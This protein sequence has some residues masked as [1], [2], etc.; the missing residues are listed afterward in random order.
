MNN[1]FNKRALVALLILTTL[2]TVWVFLAYLKLS[3]VE[4]STP[5]VQDSQV[6]R[7]SIVDS[8][9]TPL[10]VQVNLYNIGITS[11]SLKKEEDFA[12]DIAP[13]LNMTKDD[14]LNLITQNHD[15]RFYYIKKKVPEADYSK[16]KALTDKKHYNFV[17]FDKIP[18]RYY[19]EN[20][21]ASNL[22]GFMGDDGVGLSGIE[23]SMQGY[24]SPTE[25]TDTHFQSFDND[26]RPRGKSIPDQYK[27]VYLTIDAGLQ[28]KLELLSRNTM[29]ETQCESMMLLAADAK[30]GEILTYISMP[31][32][33]LN[34]YTKASPKETVDR[35]AVVMFEP[36]SVFKI[37]TV[38][39][40]KDSGL[41][42]EDESFLCDGVYTKRTN[43]GETIRIKCL[44]HHGWVTA[45]DA[46]RYS[47]NDALAQ[48]ADRMSDDYFI[49]RIRDMG[50][51]KKTFIEL[52]SETAGLVKDSQST[53]W[54]ARSK[55]TISIGQE[56]SV[57][58]IQM[59][60]AASAI[61]NGGIPLKLTVIKK[62]TQKDGT[63]VY[64]HTPLPDERVLSEATARYILSCMQTTAETGTGSRARLHGVTIGVKTGTAQM[65]SPTGGYS[66]TDFLSNCMAI[67]PVEDPKIILYIVVVKAK[68][69]TYAGR[70]VAPVIAKAA[71]EIIDYLGLA[72]GDAQSFSH[73]GKVNIAP[74][75]IEK[76][77]TGSLL[78]NFLGMTLGDLRQFMA[79]NNIK[80]TDPIRFVINGSGWVREQN[81]PAGSPITADMTIELNLSMDQDPIREE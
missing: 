51:G 45:R 10:A 70:I 56:I 64:E 12:T 53:T 39:V 18:G 37:F 40:A 69:E 48:I 57:S 65:A 68:G 59:V 1:F 17:V 66:D 71:D 14:L 81:P 24:L 15:T 67:F 30:T 31:E 80:S 2:W 29:D 35:P 49:M 26:G 47:C 74:K 76:L 11:N 41:I 55:A 22:I 23:Y 63:L 36:G 20:T 61:A 21:L 28:Y 46:L 78:P 43:R 8:K 13:L 62:I 72:R 60:H 27:N 33:N 42:T 50:F 44:E 73:T 7:G 19:P 54:S 32:A 79:E 77:T 75:E 52:P 58:A 16:I 38:G 9:G 4:M 3:L 25:T 6:L 5:Q 34:E